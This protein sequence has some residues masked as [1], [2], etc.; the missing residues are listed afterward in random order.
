[1]SKNRT[2]GRLEGTH[3]FPRNY[4]PKAR[5]DDGFLDQVNLTTEQLGETL[6]QG[7]QSV[8]MIEPARRKSDT[9]PDRQV[10]VG[11]SCCITACQRAKE[12]NGRIDP[13]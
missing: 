12:R 6:A 2:A 8:K 11:H 10:H 7:L 3:A 1:M 5:S 4:L 13:Q 9:R